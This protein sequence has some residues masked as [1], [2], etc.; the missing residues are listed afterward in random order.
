MKG[1]SNLVSEVAVIDASGSLV[2]KNPVADAAPDRRGQGGVI[3]I[4]FRAT[5]KKDLESD[6]A[7]LR[8][9]QSLWTLVSR[10]PKLPA[11]LGKLKT[12]KTEKAL[13]NE[14]FAGSF[15]GTI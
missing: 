11:F 6:L 3:H 7:I 2:A 1:R 12:R 15:E 4:N 13:H 5:L 9:I 10:D 8:E 14:G